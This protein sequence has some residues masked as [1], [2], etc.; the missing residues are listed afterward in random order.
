MNVA[1]S[2]QQK[3]SSN[4]VKDA[5]A[6]REGLGPQ[7]RARY[8]EKLRLIVGADPYKLAPTSWIHD[9]PVI[10]PSVAYPVIVNYLVFLQSPYAAEN[11]KSYKGFEAVCGWV[12][13]TQCQVVNN[14]FYCEGQSK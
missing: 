5:K 3:I 6:Y 4:S 9:D 7:E 10:L 8:L 12:R 11:F 14:R 1:M 13:E 2:K